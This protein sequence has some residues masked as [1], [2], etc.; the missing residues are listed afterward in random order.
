VVIR[1]ADPALDGAA[2]A[3][4]YAPYVLD[5]VASFEERAP[6]A[7][8]MAERI[9]RVTARYPW[10]VAEHDGTQRG[11]AHA[12]EHRSRAAYRWAAEVAV[13]VA[14]DHHRRGLGRALYD[15]LF[16]LLG[17]Q[18]LQVALAGITLPNDASVGLHEACGFKPIGVFHRIGWKAGAWWDVGWWEL[19][20][21]S[22]TD[23]PPP[24]PE[25]P[26]G[27]RSRSGSELRLPRGA[28][29]R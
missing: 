19:E 18:G 28:P 26:R 4:I 9:G 16:E 21:I 2:C 7:A 6:D 10:L 11:Y 29:G 17:R 24:E 20:L 15:A 23:G 13:Y 25:P 5:S 3:A 1:H 12:T 8:E 14:A 22:P 27:S